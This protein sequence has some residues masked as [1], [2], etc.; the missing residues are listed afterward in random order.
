MKNSYRLRKSKKLN[1]VKHDYYVTT[2]EQTNNVIRDFTV[3]QEI[4]VTT[5]VVT[6]NYLPAE[7]FP[8]T[9]KSLPIA[10][11][12]QTFAKRNYLQKLRESKS[13]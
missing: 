5:G 13:G 12:N 11:I 6:H 7:I 1:F 3:N 10:R 8:P 2:S 4:F 9:T